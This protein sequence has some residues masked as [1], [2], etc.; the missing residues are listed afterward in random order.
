MKYKLRK[1]AIEKLL[2]DTNTYPD[3]LVAWAFTMYAEQA[4]HGGLAKTVPCCVMEYAGKYVLYSSDGL[5]GFFWGVKVKD[6]IKD[7]SVYDFWTKFVDDRDFRRSCIERFY[8]LYPGA[9]RAPW[10]E[11][12]ELLEKA[13]KIKKMK[14]EDFMKLLK[15]QTKNKPFRKLSL[16]KFL[17]K[18]PKFVAW[19]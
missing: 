1:Q 7:L 13:G 10:E 2:R 8:E 14:L 17:T 19:T 9:Y 6:L 12:D 15:D 18:R 11:F 3:E 4:L 5:E 16:P